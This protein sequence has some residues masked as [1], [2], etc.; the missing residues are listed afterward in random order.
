[1]TIQTEITLA[2]Y[3][4]YMRSVLQASTPHP[5]V[6]LMVFGMLIAIPFVMFEFARD[7]EQML[8]LMVGFL[9]GW[10]GLFF[11]SRL[12]AGKLV[13]APDGTILGRKTLSITKEGVRQT[14]D[15]ADGFYQ[16]SAVRKLMVTREHIFLM[17]DN[18]AG[19]IVPRR[20]FG[21][22]DEERQF[23][24]EIEGWSGQTSS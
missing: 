15:R 7:R 3:R 22:E 4:A 13:P 2:D 1:M 16:W 12:R 11:I 5:A 8:D 24:R 14:S 23:L 6:R 20:S 18:I 19:F 10:L 9:V 21:S 17:L